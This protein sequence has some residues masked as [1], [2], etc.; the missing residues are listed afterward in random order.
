MAKKD[1]FS[2]DYHSR[3]HLRD[4]RKDF[5]L[6]GYGLYWCIVEILHEQGGSIKETDIAPIAYD[7]R[8]DEDMLKAILYNY[9]MFQVKK[10]RV[11]SER[12][13]DNLKKREEISE[14]RKQAAESRWQGDDNK[15]IPEMV[16]DEDDEVDDPDAAKQFYIESMEVMFNAFM[17]ENDIDDIL[18]KHNVYDYRPLF[19]AVVEELRDKDYVAINRKNIPVYRV[20]QVINRHIKVHG[21]IQNL[22]T[23]V[24]DVEKRYAQ[25]K[26]KN[27]TNYMIAALYNAALMDTK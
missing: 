26:I 19:R 7:L 3:D 23:A 10:G 16:L 11:Y 15:S 25:G 13:I 8:A 5:G 27:K 17:E 4:V 14:K 2:H 20:L 6:E 12:V 24:R 1:Y 9:G 22:D 21:S 18:G